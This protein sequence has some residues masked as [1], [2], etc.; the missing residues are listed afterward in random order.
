MQVTAT[1]LNIVKWSTCFK[2]ISAKKT[3]AFF[4]PWNA[5]FEENGKKVLA[6]YPAFQN[7]LQGKK[8]AKI[9]PA[10]YTDLEAYA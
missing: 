9:V 10:M 3:G 2:A 7:A 8:A 5:H 6:S 1:Q 4:V